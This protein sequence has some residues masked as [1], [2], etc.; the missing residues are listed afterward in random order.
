MRGVDP[1]SPSPQRETRTSTR[2]SFARYEFG[3]LSHSLGSEKCGPVKRNFC[4]ALIFLA[5]NLARGDIDKLNPED[6]Q[7]SRLQGKE[8]EAKIVVLD[9][10]PDKPLAQLYR[11]WRNPRPKTK[12]PAEELLNLRHIQ[13]SVRRP[14]SELSSLD[15]KKWHSGKPVRSLKENKDFDK[16]LNPLYL[17]DFNRFAYKRNRKSQN[18]GK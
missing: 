7:K 6:P 4:M 15:K 3:K 9:D 11:A 8:F 1:A 2:P 16:V 17:K 13:P 14:P 12:Q 5:G 18:K 10:V